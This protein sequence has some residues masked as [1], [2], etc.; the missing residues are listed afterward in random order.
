MNVSP[1]PSR[2]KVAAHLSEASVHAADALFLTDGRRLSL[3]QIGR[4]DRDGLATLFARLSLESRHRRFLSP[5]RELTPR[6]LAYFTDIDHFNHEAIAAIDQRDGSIVGVARYVRDADRAGLAEVAI[7]VADAFQ[8]MGIGTA[9]ASRTVQCARA[10][11]YTLL[12]AT[13]LWENRPARGL[14]RRHGFRARHSRG[15]EIEYELTLEEVAPSRARAAFNLAK[16]SS[17]QGRPNRQAW[18]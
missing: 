13:T 11:G 15:G 18:R 1:E 9:L 12:T 10:N 6:E 8:R 5:K 4:A 3:R 7:E 16:V 17:A 14:L 2:D